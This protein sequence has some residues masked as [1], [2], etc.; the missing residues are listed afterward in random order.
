MKTLISS[1]QEIKEKLKSQLEAKET[2]EQIVKILQDEISKL[3]DFNGDY[4]LSM[5]PR[6][7]RLATVM[8]NDLN[9]YTSILGLAR[10]E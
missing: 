3:V 7:A 8:L 2:T 4:I 6:Q 1:Y 5:T 10:L 9:Q